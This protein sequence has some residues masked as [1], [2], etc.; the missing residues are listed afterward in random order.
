MHFKDSLK[1]KFPTLDYSA[2]IIVI[3]YVNNSKNIHN[4]SLVKFLLSFSA[5]AS[6]FA[7]FAQI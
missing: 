6:A 4:L 3:I 1:L 2:R 7:P 5:S